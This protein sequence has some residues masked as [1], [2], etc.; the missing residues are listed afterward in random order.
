MI[1]NNVLLCPSY[2]DVSEHLYDSFPALA[3]ANRMLAPGAAFADLGSGDDDDDD[4]I[5]DEEDDELDDDEFY[6]EDELIEEDVDDLGY[7]DDIDEK[8]FEEPFYEE[9]FEDDLEDI[10]ED[11]LDDL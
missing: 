8:E 3:N 10:E 11:E 1:T 7:M 9:D 4:D 6:E 2:A 5:E